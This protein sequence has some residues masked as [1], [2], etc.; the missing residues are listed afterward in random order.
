[1]CR[2]GWR[3]GDGLDVG[4]SS[5]S[6][7]LDRTAVLS[8][9]SSLLVVASGW[10]DARGK[11]PYVGLPFLFQSGLEVGPDMEG[12]CQPPVMV[13][14]TSVDGTQLSGSR[15]ELIGLACDEGG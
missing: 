12:C 6:P 8:L 13:T 7:L 1:M 15:P 2:D 10:I 11:V 5:P 3:F 14:E 4:E 9:L